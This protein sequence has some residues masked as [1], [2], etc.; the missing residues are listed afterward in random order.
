MDTEPEPVGE[1]GVCSELGLWSATV[2]WVLQVRGTAGAETSRQE[3]G[4]VWAFRIQHLW[5]RHL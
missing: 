5:L 1:T 3:G 2:G 4:R